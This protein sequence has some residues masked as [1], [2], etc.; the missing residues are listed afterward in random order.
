MKTWCYYLYL[1]QH[2]LIASVEV[3]LYVIGES[4]IKKSYGPGFILLMS[5]INL[6]IFLVIVFPYL[7][8][9]VEIKLMV[10]FTHQSF[11]LPLVLN[12]EMSLENFIDFIITMQHFYPFTQLDPSRKFCYLFKIFLKF[13]LFL[14]NYCSIFNLCL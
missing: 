9:Q 4:N 1:Y 11:Y 8:I 12:S 14:A 2:Y 7:D 6:F 10:N 5:S 13:Y 3:I